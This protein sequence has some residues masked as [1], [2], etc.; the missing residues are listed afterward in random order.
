MKILRETNSPQHPGGLKQRVIRILL[1]CTGEMQQFHTFIQDQIFPLQLAE[2]CLRGISRVILLNNPVSGAVILAALLLESPWQAML[3]VLGLLASTVTAIMLGQDCEEVSGGLHGFNGML[4]ALLMGVFSSA[5]EWYLWLLLPVCLG[6][7]TTTFLSSGLAPVLDRWDLPFSV[8]P[9]NTV[10]LLYLACTGT[11]TPYFPN[12]P[13]LPLGAPES[14][15]HTQVNVP[16]LLQ[17]AVLGVGQ[18]FACE[19]LGPSLL[20]LGAV[21]LFSPILAF[22]AFLGSVI[23]TVAGLSVSV[24]HRFLYSGLSGFNGA[25]GCMGVGAGF[26]FS[27]RTH[28]LS[29]ASAVL[30]AYADIAL[31]KLLAVVDLPASSWAATLT[32]TLMLLLTG[33]NLREYRIPTRKVTSPELNLDSQDLDLDSVV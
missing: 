10:I 23:G 3:G 9:F 13:V 31:R 27:W 4:V 19:T 20:I 11:S 15:N 29:I 2:W 12:Y 6:G 32:G 7:A 24:Q 21:L 22:Y 30:S 1:Y 33:K 28:L 26:I 5:G 17:G 8:F 16:Q 18:I 25:L 14:T